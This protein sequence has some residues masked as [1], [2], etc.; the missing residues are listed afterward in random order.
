M[1]NHADEL[2]P[3]SASLPPPRSPHN[4]L[5]IDD[6]SSNRDASSDRTA[7]SPPNSGGIESPEIKTQRPL[8]LLAQHGL[9]TKTHHAFMGLGAA[10][11]ERE[12]ERERLTHNAAMDF[13]AHAQQLASQAAVAAAT[14]QHLPAHPFVPFGAPDRFLPSHVTPPSS[15]H[16]NG[17]DGGAPSGSPN[18][19]WTFEEQFKQVGP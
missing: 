2:R 3:N 19:H 7:P 4:S 9:M 18:H 15:P 8:G 1:R 10:M 5:P 12:R 14:T 13:Y 16:T 11:L 6:Q 17:S